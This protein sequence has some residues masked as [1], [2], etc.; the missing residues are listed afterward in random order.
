VDANTHLN[1]H[2]HR[3]AIFHSYDH[4][5]RNENPHSAKTAT[6]T[7]SAT[8][9]QDPSFYYAED[10]TFS[11]ISPEDWTPVDFGLKYRVLVGPQVGGYTLNLVFMQEKA[12]FPMAFFTALIQ[13]QLG[14]VLQ[15][16][17]SIREEF[18]VTNEGENYFRWEITHNMNGARV[19]QVLYFYESGDWILSVTYSRLDGAGSEYDRLVDD[20]MKTVRF[21]R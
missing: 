11:L 21:N 12:E 15:N 19:R 6:A 2:A 16:L 18:L 13:D 8:P 9:T 17:K 5:D 3:D 10:N 4:A 1:C 20:A 14:E 7:A